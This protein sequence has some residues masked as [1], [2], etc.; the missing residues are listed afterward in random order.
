MECLEVTYTCDIYGDAIFNCIDSR[1]FI[2]LWKE[3]NSCS[4][5]REFMDL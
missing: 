1:T 5:S 2:A 3:Y 4:F